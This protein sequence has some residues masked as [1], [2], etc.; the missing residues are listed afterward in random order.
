MG[1]YID[2]SVPI[3]S[4]MTVYPGD[5]RRKCVGRVGREQRAT[6]PM[7]VSIAAASTMERTSM[8]PGTLS[9]AQELDEVPLDR[10]LGPCWVA[11]LTAEPE[12]VYAASLHNAD[13]PVG[14]QTAAAE[15]AKQPKRLLARAVESSFHLYPPFGSRVVRAT[16][17]IHG[18]ARLPD[19]RPSSGDG[20]SCPSHLAGQQCGADR[21]SE[22]CVTCRPA[23]T[24]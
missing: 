6:R 16:R 5:D 20:L 18:G 24:S 1:R 10:W 14:H 22:P 9:T 17:H 23:P 4:R 15:D 12:C 13:I 2:I 3:S 19:H 8:P 11:D 21:V 7:L